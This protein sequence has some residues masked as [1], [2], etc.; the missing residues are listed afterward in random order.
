M[1]TTALAM[2][3][4]DIAA[5]HWN[6]HT[7]RVVCFGSVVPEEFGLERSVDGPVKLAA[8]YRRGRQID[9]FA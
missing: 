7:G 9:D 1:P 8:A 2:S 6:H 5:Y 4:N 3:N